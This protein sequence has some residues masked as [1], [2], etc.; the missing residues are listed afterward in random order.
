MN[1]D[2]HI[3]GSLAT[4]RS[5]TYIFNPICSEWPKL[6]TIL[7]FL[8]AVGLIIRLLCFQLYVKLSGLALC[9]DCKDMQDTAL[10][11]NLVLIIPRSALS[12]PDK[13][14]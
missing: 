8:S 5:E 3:F 12:A 4:S 6:H 14:G 7:A 9:C 11:G 13:K 1:L 2:F 10:H